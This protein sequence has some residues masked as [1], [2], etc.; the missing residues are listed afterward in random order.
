MRLRLYKSEQMKIMFIFL[1]REFLFASLDILKPT[2]DQIADDLSVNYFCKVIRVKILGAN[3]IVPRLV[4]CKS[5]I[6]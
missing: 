2:F 4:V 6:G 1:F 5:G 3:K